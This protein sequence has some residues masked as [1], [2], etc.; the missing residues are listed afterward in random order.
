VSLYRGPHS[1]ISLTS[2][3]S[4]VF[5]SHLPIHT[6]RILRH[7]V[8]RDQQVRALLMEHISGIFCTPLPCQVGHTLLGLSLTIDN[9]PFMPG[10][11]SCGHGCSRSLERYAA[12]HHKLRL[13]SRTCASAEKRVNWC[14][15]LDDSSLDLHQGP[16]RATWSGINPPGANFPLLLCS[17][18][19][20]TRQMLVITFETQQPSP[21]MSL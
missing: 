16:M 20:Q 13:K 8:I 11:A 9:K 15:G 14:L 19:R 1:L 7:S 17:L 4:L 21:V 2:H 18:S 12:R 6:T 5:T 3:P 10:A